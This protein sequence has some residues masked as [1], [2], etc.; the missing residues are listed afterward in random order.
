[1]SHNY[2]ERNL[3]YFCLTHSVSGSQYRQRLAVG[4]CKC[5]IRVRILFFGNCFNRN[6]ANG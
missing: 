6:K 5:L 4:I 1:M 3:S 2:L